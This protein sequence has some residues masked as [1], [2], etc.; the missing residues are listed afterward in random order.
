MTIVVTINL[1]EVLQDPEKESNTVFK[2][3]NE[4]LLKANPEKSHLLTNATR[5]IQISIGGMAISNSKYE[6]ILGI[7]IDKK[8]I[9]EPHLRSYCKKDQPQTKCFC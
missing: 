6:K 5:E 7:S 2:W 4:N 3:F 9:F 1:N 8:L